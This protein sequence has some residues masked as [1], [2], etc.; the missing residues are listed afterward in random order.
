L[1]AARGALL[2][3]SALAALGLAQSAAAQSVNAASAQSEQ[4]SPAP[5]AN[6]P[7]AKKTGQ[8]N[9]IPTPAP[10]SAS[11][12]EAN[13]STGSTGDRDIVVTASRLDLLGTATT[14]SQGHIT[15][16]EIEL[17]PIVRPGQLF[18]SIPGLVVTIHS[19][20]GK[21][22]Q[23]LI[24]GFNLDHGTDFAN[25]VDDMPVNRPT[26]THGQGYS[27]LAFLMPQIISGID[28]T[29]GPYYANIGDFG[30]VASSHARVA[31]EIANQISATVGTDGYQDLFMGGTAHF[32][33]DE[34]LLGALELGH[35]D[36]PW[37]PK[38][39]FKKVNAALRYSKG[40][41][42]DGWSLTGMYY[43]S[44][45]GLITDQPLRA[46][47]SGLIDRFGT[48]DPTDHSKS[49]RYSLSAHMD[50]QVGSNGKLAV[51]L[52]GIHATMTLWNDFTHFLDD[53]ING[54]QEAQN[55]KRDTIG[56]NASYTVH[57]D[58]GKISSDT[59]IGF[60]GRYDGVFVTRQ[61]T[62]NRTTVLDYCTLQQP[63]GSVTTYPTVNTF[64][65]ADHVRLL[66]LGGYLQ[67]TTN[68]TDWIRT[69]L[70]VREEYYHAT[71][72]SDVTG[73]GG[74]GDQWLLQPKAN[75]V[76]GPFAKTE[77]YLSWGRGFHSDD[78]RGVFG[79][80]PE[81]GIPLAG[82]ATPLLAST[83]G[84]E[85]GLRTDVIPKVHIQ[86]AAFQQDFKSE[87]TY[88]ADTGQDEA[89]APSRRRGLEF[90][91]EYHPFRWLELNTDLA[92]TKAR[93]HTNDLAAYGLA[94]PFIAEAPKFTGSFGVLVSNLGPW[95]GGL[96]WRRLGPY[97]LIDGDKLPESKGYSEFNLDVAY[98][99]PHGWRLGA[100]V[101]NLLNSHDYAAEYDYVSRLPGEPA[102]GIDDLQV[103]PLEPRA[104]RFTLTK[105]F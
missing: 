5:A 81:Q 70:G 16:R 73:T 84:E 50:K 77:V 72:H 37:K 48:L 45:G 4:A 36:G 28:Y 68:W 31:N 76:F 8:A 65:N 14:A 43:Q 64:C 58:L 20:E 94:G 89:G 53:P 39:D 13:A 78:V 85:I 26:N 54:D 69:I 24:R 56:G 93:Y 103:H 34:R 86:I 59:T 90:S 95:S 33:S 23:Y 41:A 21:A 46:I 83:T 1:V 99:L 62:K 30:S 66:D 18:E 71:D 75:L 101:S 79:T 10:P 6:G 9:G 11:T 100:T 7:A 27:D 98:Q 47:T 12:I 102:G 96:Q 82:G 32:D 91:A 38:Q 2:S 42:T 67:N 74:R 17:R 35:Y 52:Y 49:L 104:A 22:N 57:A 29:K 63:G 19:G 61:H 55:E 60:Q 92:F 15:Q 25:F 80:V 40:D 87:L 51:S 105:T 97:P 44:S 88:N 3:A